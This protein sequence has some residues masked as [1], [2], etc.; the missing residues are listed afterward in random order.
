MPQDENKLEVY[1]KA[2]VLCKDVYSLSYPKEEIYGLQ[3]QIRRAATSIPLLISEG[4]GRST[5]KD[6]AHYLIQARG[7]AKEVVTALK[8]SKELGFI[9]YQ[10]YSKLYEEAEYIAAMLSSLIKRVM[11][12][13]KNESKK[14]KEYNQPPTTNTQ[15]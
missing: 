6:F 4:S 9:D 2:M 12:G 5:I 13:G 11:D 14:Q 1:N 3:S 8:L 10:A 15:R 7:S